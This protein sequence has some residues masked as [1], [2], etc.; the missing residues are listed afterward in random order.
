M[1]I[2]D[3]YNFPYSVNARKVW[4][5][6]IN[7]YMMLNQNWQCMMMLI[8]CIYNCLLRWEPSWLVQGAKLTALHL[9]PGM[10]TPMA[11]SIA[12]PASAVLLTSQHWCYC[13]S[14]GTGVRNRVP[15]S[16]LLPAKQDVK[17]VHW[18]RWAGLQGS[19]LMWRLASVIKYSPLGG[20]W[21][22]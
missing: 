9:F 4:G 1:S 15:A 6:K 13:W 10:P 3:I 19:L 22:K 18:E 17:G 20:D 12:R 7:R 16:P 14:Q 21:I 2:N 8:L 5:G 11:L